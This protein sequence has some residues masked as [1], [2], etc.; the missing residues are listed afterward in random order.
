M[1]FGVFVR[2][3]RLYVYSCFFFFA[4]CLLFVVYDKKQ[5]PNDF[6]CVILL[7]VSVSIFFIVVGSGVCFQDF[8]HV[9]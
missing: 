5:C 4:A 3:V 9:C 8:T 6:S 1:A 2:A 7:S